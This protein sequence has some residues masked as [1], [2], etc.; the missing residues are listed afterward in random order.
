[1]ANLEKFASDMQWWCQF[2]NLGYDQSNRWDLRVGGETDCSALVIGVLKG[3]G[4]DTGGA[5]YTGNMARELSARGWDVLP[6]YFQKQRGDILLNHANHVA[7]Y[8]GNGMLAQASIDERGDIAGGQSGDQTDYETNVRSY[9]DYPWSCILRYTGGYTSEYNYEPEGSKYNPNDY[10][11]E[12]VRSVQEKLI[13]RGYNVGSD[14]ADGILGENTFNAIQNFQRDH[15]GL[16]V[17]GI[18]GPQTI[19]A[20][21]GGDTVPTT[22]IQPEVDGYWG[23]VTTRMLQMVMGTPADGVV[24]SQPES[25]SGILMGCTSGWEFVSDSASEGSTVIEAIQGELGVEKD[26]IFGPDTINALSARYGIEGDGKIDSPSIT[27]KELQ[28]RLLEGSW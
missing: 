4:F 2:G 12:Y 23:E 28:E 25:N 16:E 15:G 7:V 13:S 1:M 10:N 5:T 3:A 26:G 18:P 22:A 11:E 17:D 21:N 8:L 27:V 24:S 19:A 20:L 6:S 9:Y 14:G